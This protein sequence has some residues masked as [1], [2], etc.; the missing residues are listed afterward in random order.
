MDDAPLHLAVGI[1][2]PDGLHKPFQ[3]VHTEQI[4]VQNSPAF[5]VVQ[6]IQPEFA[7][8]VLSNPHTQDVFHAVHGDTQD[9][10]CCLYFLIFS[11]PFALWCTLHEVESMEIFSK[12]ASIQ[13][14]YA[15]FLLMILMLRL[16][17]LLLVI[18]PQSK[19]PILWRKFVI[20]YAMQTRICH[21]RNVL[22]LLYMSISRQSDN[23]E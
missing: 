13:G 20:S 17:K 1:D 5:E 9:Y 19:E 11:P 12:S 21:R 7:A 2:R 15:L 4:D 6:H 14:N 16:K 22:M 18:C 8:L 3:S 10:I 23:K